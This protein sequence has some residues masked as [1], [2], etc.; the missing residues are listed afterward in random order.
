MLADK[1]TGAAH[2]LSPVFRRKLM[3]RLLVP[4][5]FTP[6]GLVRA[7]RHAVGARTIRSASAVLFLSLALRAQQT[8]STLQPAPQPSVQIDLSAVGYRAPS[9]MD[10]LTEGESSVSLDYVDFNHVLLTFNRK[11]L[12]HRLPDC[13]PDHQDRLIHAAILE[14]PSGKVVSETDWYLH[15]RRRYL[16]PLGPGRFLLRK[17][18]TL[19]VV[20]SG[21]REKLLMTSPRDLLW[22]EV[23]PD[24]RQIVIETPS[25]PDTLKDVKPQS[26]ASPAKPQLKFVAQFLDADTLAPQRTI[27]L[28]QLVTMNGTSS[29]Y[30]DFLHKGDLWL[31]RFGPTPRRRHNIAR[32]R[33]Q[34]PP[35][36]FYSSNNSLLVGRCPTAGCDYSVTAFTV[37]GHRLWRQHWPRFRTFPAVARN[38]D[39]SRFAVSTL[40]F[41]PAP[42]TAAHGLYDEDDITQPEISQVD[43][44]QQDLQIFETAS[45]TPV[46]SIDV[47][48]AVM[49][50]QN[51]SLS[52]DGRHLAVL[53]AASLQLYD[54]PPSS[55][56]DK[57]QFAALQTDVPE[58]YTLAAISDSAVPVEAAAGAEAAQ[59][60]DVADATPTD[61]SSPDEHADGSTATGA[62]LADNRPSSS[63]DNAN[64]ES[65]SPNSANAS[66]GN[67]NPSVASAPAKPAPPASVPTFR[68]SAKAV[69][70]DVVVTDSKG[71]PVNGLSQQDFQLAEDGKPQDLRSFR[72]FAAAGDPASAAPAAPPAKPSPNLFSNNTGAAEPG[73]VTM[74]LL[75]LVNTP[76]QDQTFA[77]QQLIKFLQ[78]KS[79]TSQLALCTMSNGP[80]HLR[81]IQGFTADETVLLAAATGK[82]G[83]PK[84]VRWQV[85]QSGTGDAVDTV[86]VLT[87]EGRSS[88]FT[89]LLSA[90]Q[91]MQAQEEVTDTD[92]R[93]SITLDSMMELARYLSGIPGRKNIVW[94]SG[95]FPI[96]IS[97]IANS[98]NSALD[99]PNYSFKIKRVTNLL[100]DAQ[101]AV[102]P[103]DVRGLV[104][105]GSGADTAAMMSQQSIQ[106]TPSF[107]GQKVIAPAPAVPASLQALGR[108]ADERETLNEFAIATGGKAFYSSNGIRQAIETSV[109]QGSNYYTLSY[110]PSNKLYDGKF[111]KIKVRLAE[112]GYTLHYREG[113]YADDAKSAARDAELARVT[114]A[115]A[116]QHGSPPS[117]QL[118][119]SV[120][121]VPV[122]GKTKVD[123]STLAD[124]LPVPKPAGSSARNAAPASAP[125]AT[126]I[127]TQI[128]VQHY[129]IDYEFDASELRFVPLTNS[130]YRNQLMLMET[131]FDSEGHLLTASA[132]VGTSDLTPDVYQKVIAGDFAVHQEVDLPVEAAS[133][134]LGIQ[135]QMTSHIGTVEIALPVPPAPDAPRHARNPLPEI[136]PD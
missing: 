49:T 66:R 135:D 136:E 48:P 69:V 121:V 109:E 78:A 117:R 71:H 108:E 104:S 122:G 13:P 10:R 18:N 38:Q 103:V 133:L 129:N 34:T 2:L 20:D 110:S 33:S 67:A 87:E 3:F 51:V 58:V 65:P 26:P 74:I 92:E 115:V 25:A 93:A 128:K 29:G 63:A 105:G 41:V 55:E 14:L 132:N 68:V 70:V 130:N 101:I 106:D 43:I 99:N 6:A 39:N 80:T 75:D 134:R 45:G 52:P 119:F 95:S 76:A 82:K 37:T 21:L 83:V 113:Y 126:Q 116:M 5:W 100:A 125:I 124:S 60:D 27:P 90:L 131:S 40:Q 96:A 50:G 53:Q 17:W 35:N 123:R 47:S 30:V 46:L 64:P 94:L 57:T 23:T 91:S 8:P 56:P 72:E 32:V 86:S 111:R 1:F 22:V 118:L 7:R 79:K 112:K 31:I 97:A 24:A 89:G 15:D 9:R 85:A 120:K 88:G 62:A 4:S 77:R 61:S 28:H 84:A 19:Y 114:R 98:G 11:Q 102:Y 107:L 12:F 59:A 73:A 42:Q 16:W 36:I 54:L 81:L 44:F 127:P